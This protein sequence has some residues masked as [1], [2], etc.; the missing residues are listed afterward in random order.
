M[1]PRAH[2]LV[3]WPG[4]SV[5][6]ESRRQSCRWCNRNAPPQAKLPPSLPLLIFV[7][8]FKLAGKFFLTIGD[9]LSGWTEIARIKHD[10]HFAGVKGL[11]DA[12]RQVF[13]TIEVPGEIA[14][15]GGSESIAEESSTFYDMLGVGDYLSSSDFPQ[16]NGRAEVVVK[17]TKRLLEANIGTEGNLQTAS[18]V[19]ALAVEKYP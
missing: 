4:I 15:D 10:S 2:A 16:G 17:T 14:S 7:D 8:Y 11:C 9:H 13:Q 19:R 3:F 5:Y 1:L 18:L 6:V 12:L